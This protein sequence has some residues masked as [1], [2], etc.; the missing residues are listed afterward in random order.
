MPIELTLVAVTALLAGLLLVGIML[1]SSRFGASG[2][3]AAERTSSRA[4]AAP[5]A[6]D[7]E[8]GADPVMR[9]V[10]WLT[11]TI[12]LLGVGISGSFQADQK[13]G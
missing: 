3:T 12:V 6:A 4:A 13:G 1:S 10:W 11:I 5:E 9:V 2:D 8:L 7:R